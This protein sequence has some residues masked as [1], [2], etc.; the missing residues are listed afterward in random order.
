MGTKIFSN[1]FQQSGQYECRYAKHKRQTSG[2]LI[3]DIQKDEP[4]FKQVQRGNPLSGLCDA[5]A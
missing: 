2:V 3:T 1:Y 5:L 4:G